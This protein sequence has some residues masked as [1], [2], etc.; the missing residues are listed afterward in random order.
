MTLQH[1]LKNLVRPQVQLIQH[2][3]RWKVRRQS[4]K[5]GQTITTR[6]QI[7]TDRWTGWMVV[8]ESQTAKEIVF[9]LR[10]IIWSSKPTISSLMKSPV[11][12]FVFSLN[13]AQTQTIQVFFIFVDHLPYY[14]YPCLLTPW[15]GALLDK[16][17]CLLLIWGACSRNQFWAMSVSVY[18]LHM[19][20]FSPFGRA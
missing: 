7:Q 20:H 10:R 2:H 9:I 15:I 19:C 18:I 14:G 5:F 3:L 4:E 17:N 13:L 16:S 8:L 1:P 11:A 12:K 6:D